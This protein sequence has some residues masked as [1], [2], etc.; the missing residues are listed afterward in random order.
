MTFTTLHRFS[1]VAFIIS[2]LLLGF[3]YVSH[4]HHMTAD[5][6]ASTSWFY[7]HLAFLGSVIAGLLGTTGFYL[8][9]A[10]ATGILGF[11]GF[12]ASFIGLV[13]IGGLDYYEVFIAPYL[14]TAFP[15]V[16]QTHGAGDAMGPVAIVFPLSGS[17]TVLG[18]MGL[19]AS[20]L[21][22]AAYPRSAMVALLA[23]SLVFGAGLSPVAG[24]LTAQIGAFVF[25]VSLIW[26]GIAYWRGIPAAKTA[27]RSTTVPAH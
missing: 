23:S 24:I 18:Y 6:I 11:C 20:N 5:V 26:S 2:G 12:L 21:R 25:G 16:I 3:S 4:P 13:L 17:V 27:R 15:Q 7:I 9:T 14:A 10:P 19:A 8:R 1:A 22:A